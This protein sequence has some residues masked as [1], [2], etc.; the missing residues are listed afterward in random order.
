MPVVKEYQQL[1]KKAGFTDYNFSA[2]EGFL[3]AKVMV[4]GLRRAGKAPTR[5]GLVDAL[6][7]MNDVDLGG[8]YISY[9]P[10]TA[11]A[12]SSST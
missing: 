4:E 12:R 11:P 3:T 8:F 10:R 7:K 1:A 9:S 2:L 6:E 5:E